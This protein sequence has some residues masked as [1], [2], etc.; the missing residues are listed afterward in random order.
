M[1]VDIY[2]STCNYIYTFI[3]FSDVLS[4]G[5]SRHWHDVVRQM[6][7]GK[8]NRLD[9][10]AIMKYFQPLYEWLKRQNEMEPVIGWITIQEDTG[11]KLNTNFLQ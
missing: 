2:I 8:S 5:A 11:L 10:D 6:T 1:H 9:A 4:I 7:R 3:L